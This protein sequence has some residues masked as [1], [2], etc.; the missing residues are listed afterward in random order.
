MPE[1]LG[2]GV[3]FGNGDRCE[4]S[5]FALVLQGRSMGYLLKAALPLS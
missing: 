2:T 4:R 5:A 1:I 3:I